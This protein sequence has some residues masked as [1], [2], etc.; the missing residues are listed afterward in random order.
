MDRCNQCKNH[1]IQT[2]N[3][4]GV[5]E[6]CSCKWGK[7]NKTYHRANCLHEPDAALFDC[8]KYEG[9]NEDGN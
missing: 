7:T 8:G 9:M 6:G 2:N 5:L 1:I 4:T 3:K